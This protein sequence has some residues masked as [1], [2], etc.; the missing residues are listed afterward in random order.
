[1]S[2]LRRVRAEVKSASAEQ[3]MMVA[4]VLLAAVAITGATVDALM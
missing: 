3:F 4:P 2:W 1:M